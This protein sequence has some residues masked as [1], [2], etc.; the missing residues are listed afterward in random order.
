M[1]GFSSTD[2]EASGSASGSARHGEQSD[3]RTLG[4]WRLE[5]RIHR[6]KWCDLH[7]AQPAVGEGSPRFDYV[8]KISR[9]TI[10]ED[11]EGA[12]QLRSE[13]AAA[14][15]AKHPHLLAV[16]DG[17]LSG[18]RPFLVMPRIEGKTLVELCGSAEI[19]LPMLLWWFRQVAQAL[20]SLHRAGWVHGD[21]KG[22]NILIDRCGHATLIDLGMAQPIGS[23][24]GG[25][26]RGTLKYAAPERLD[27][28]SPG[29]QQA[30][31]AEDIYAFGTLLAE[32][33]PRNSLGLEGM[34]QL[35]A[36]A[37]AHHAGLRPAAKSIAAIL[38]R[39]EIESLHMYIR[40]PRGAAAR[41]A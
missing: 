4:I 30:S 5:E 3:I 24:R 34:N 6:G 22:A 29:G 17:Q 2:R 25:A 19:K 21:V 10:H 27:G 26:F 1:F 28:K 16:L 36:Q 35:I 8:L 38:L 32:L 31:A 18:L 23:P 41:V 20:D 37:T 40:P 12:R 7:R 11:P 13:A 14:A 33:V 39:L 9:S 15:A